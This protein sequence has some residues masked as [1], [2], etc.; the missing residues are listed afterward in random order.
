MLHRANEGAQSEQDL[1]SR[2]KKKETFK[3]GV[4]IQEPCQEGNSRAQLETA[5]LADSW[6]T[7]HKIIFR[8]RISIVGGQ[9]RTKAVSGLT[10]DVATE[11]SS[12][13]QLGS[14]TDNKEIS[15][16]AEVVRK[17]IKY[18]ISSIDVFSAVSLQ[19]LQE[20]VEEEWL[21]I[22]NKFRRTRH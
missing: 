12:A 6:G 17:K 2:Q 3:E 5:M 4:A 8:Q 1:M 15:K 11:V 19:P 14:P 10:D 9:C 20:E 18:K 13:D 22:L 7:N 21:E 16:F